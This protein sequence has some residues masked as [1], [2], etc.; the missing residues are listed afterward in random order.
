MDSKHLHGFTTLFNRGFIVHHYL[1]AY[2]EQG[3]LQYVK[4]LISFLI[5]LIYERKSIFP[6]IFLEV[7]VR[8]ELTYQAFAEPDLTNRTLNH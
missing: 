8:F 6:N 2:F 4:E 3:N 7:E 5:H 1:F